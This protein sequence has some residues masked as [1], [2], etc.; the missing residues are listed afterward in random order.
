VNQFYSLLKVTN[1]KFKFVEDFSYTIALYQSRDNAKQH[2]CNETR[3]NLMLRENEFQNCT[4]SKGSVLVSF[5]I[6]QNIING[7]QTLDRL[8]AFVANNVFTLTRPDGSKLN[9]ESSSVYVNGNH[10]TRSGPIPP[11]PG[12]KKDRDSEKVAIGL[13]ISLIICGLILILFLLL[14]LLRKNNKHKVR[15]SF[16]VFFFNVYFC[17]LIFLNEV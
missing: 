17:I 4:I 12:I 16:F 6:V 15:F 2:I 7:N 14:V 3:T 10:E 1:L 11:L 5:E 9:T 8:N 13:L